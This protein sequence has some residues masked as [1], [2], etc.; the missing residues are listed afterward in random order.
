M[1]KMVRAGQTVVIFTALAVLWLAF[2]PPRRWPSDPLIAAGDRLFMTQIHLK[3]LS[4]QNWRLEDQLG[5]VVIVNFWAT[6]CPP[7]REETP[8]LIRLANANHARGLKVVG[9]S[10]DEGGLTPVAQFAERYHI[11][12]PVLL[13]STGFALADRVESLPT[14]FLI[15]QRGRIAKTYIGAVS[16]E[17]FQ[18]DVDRLLKTGVAE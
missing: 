9:I 3:D 18:R 2:S 11:P 6:W 7:C 14:T 17:S 13:P 8:G 4:G 5:K 16:Q 1:P 15:D 10:M 12:Y